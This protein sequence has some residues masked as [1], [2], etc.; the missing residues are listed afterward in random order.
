MKSSNTLKAYTALEKRK[1]EERL[2][3]DILILTSDWNNESRIKR[4]T[5]ISGPQANDACSERICAGKNW[6]AAGKI[7]TRRA[8]QLQ[9]SFMVLSS[10]TPQKFV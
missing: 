10:V 8:L 2:Q 5:E 1:A 9:F 6:A 7:P 3:M 4:I